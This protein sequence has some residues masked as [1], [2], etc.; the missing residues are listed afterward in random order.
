MECNQVKMLT[1]CKATPSRSH[2]AL[3]LKL[4]FSRWKVNNRDWNHDSQPN[5]TTIRMNNVVFYKIFLKWLGLQ[6]L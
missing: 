4:A 5:R 3:S 1:C 6:I 2:V